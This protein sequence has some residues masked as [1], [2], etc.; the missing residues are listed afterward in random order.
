M[1]AS[2]QYVFITE[3]SWF[4]KTIPGWVH[5]STHIIISD[6]QCVLLKAH[7]ENIDCIAMGSYLSSKDIYSID[8]EELDKEREVISLTKRKLSELSYLSGLL[9]SISMISSSSRK[10]SISLE[11][12]IEANEINDI[13]LVKGSRFNAMPFETPRGGVLIHYLLSKLCKLKNIKYS[14]SNHQLKNYYDCKKS[15]RYDK[16]FHLSKGTGSNALKFENRNSHKSSLLFLYCYEMCSEDLE[17]LLKNHNSAFKGVIGE[18]AAPD[19]IYNFNFLNIK[20]KKNFRPI[21][22]NQEVTQVF[23]EA[24]KLILNR[25]SFEEKHLEKLSSRLISSY[26]EQKNSIEIIINNI[27]EKVLEHKIHTIYLTAFPSSLQTSIAQFFSN[28]GLSVIMRQ[29][30]ALT[31]PFFHKRCFEEGATYVANS[32]HVIPSNYPGNNEML[33]FMPRPRKILDQSLNDRKDKLKVKNILIADDLYF[34]FAEYKIDNINFLE[35]FMSKASKDFQFIIRSH[36][37]YNANSFCESNFS[38]FIIED[39]RQISASES[40]SSASVCL[41]PHCQLTSLACDAINTNVPVIFFVPN[42]LYKQFS[43]SIDLWKFPTVASSPDDLLTLILSIERDNEKKH[44]IL[45][46]QQ[47]WLDQHLGKRTPKIIKSKI[48]KVT[49]DQVKLSRMKYFQICG[50]ALITNLYNTYKLWI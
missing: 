13:T 19:Q 14:V 49:R 30:G 20:N 11:R 40:L 1:L 23:E 8:N 10:I 17:P 36:P 42:T 4:E 50:R 15:D 44:E 12:I 25:N 3:P 46:R 18:W 9:K 22:F 5:A 35:N 39:S 38:N 16:S 32:P 45:L 26:F 28:I 43:F 29:H 7:R 33:D 2:K 37:R 47:E 34:S 27:Y 31:D 48:T 41:I 6:S 21:D 24:I